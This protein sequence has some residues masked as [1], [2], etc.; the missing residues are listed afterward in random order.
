VK[1]AAFLAGAAAAAAAAVAARADQYDPAMTSDAPA[2]RVLLG[3]GT[4]APLPGGG[5][6]FDG[7]P[8]RGTFARMDDGS[9]VSTVKLEH[10]LYSV[11][12]REIPA[13]WPASA[14]QAQAICARTYVLAKSNPRRGYDVV[15]SELDQVYTGLAGESPAASAAVDTTAGSVLR[16][17]DQ[18]AQIVYSSCCGGRTEASS[19]IW[20][21]VPIPYLS[22]V[23]CTTCTDS[24]YYRWTRPLWFADVS[25][26]CAPGVGALRSLRVASI[27]PSGRA[28]AIIA[29]GSSGSVTIKGT[30]FRARI[31]ARALPSLLI[32]GMRASE[33]GD[34]V[35]IEGGGLGHGVGLCQWGARGLAL[36]G[37]AVADILNFYFPGTEIGHD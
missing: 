16:Y 6:S 21:A 27:D 11:V 35:T 24:P 19:E 5:F 31:G 12:P 15:P 3:S 34:G 17:G 28:R 25:A 13:S 10:Y 4:A 29:Q 23:V 2:L 7:R 33:A 9:I 8:Y 1:R 14:L 22:G 30:D 37:A 18:F 20:G 36:K 26:R 32:A